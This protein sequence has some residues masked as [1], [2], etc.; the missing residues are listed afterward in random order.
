MTGKFAFGVFE[1]WSLPHFEYKES[2]WQSWVTIT[3]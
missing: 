2:F 1:K 3:E